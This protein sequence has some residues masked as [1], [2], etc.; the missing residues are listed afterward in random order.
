M[1]TYEAAGHGKGVIGAMSSFG[2]KS[3]LKRDIWFSD[4]QEICEYWDIS[5][6]PRIDGCMVKHL[7]DCKPDHTTNYAIK[8]LCDC[9]DYLNFRFD[10]CCRKQTPQEQSLLNEPEGQDIISDKCYLDAYD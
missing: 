1:R 10:D 7:F 3:I 8:F 5:K 6:D 2:E 9:D 4:S